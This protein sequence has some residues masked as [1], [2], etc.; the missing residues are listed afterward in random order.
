[1]NVAIERCIRIVEP[2]SSHMYF[3]IEVL[4]AALYE[5]QSNMQNCNGMID[6]PQSVPP[7][8]WSRQGG[9][10]Y[11][12]SYG[13]SVGALVPREGKVMA[14][15]S[16][17]KQKRVLS[18][19]QL[20]GP[21]FD[22][23]KKHTVQPPS[24][25][26]LSAVVGQERQRSKPQGS[27]PPS[28]Q[29]AHSSS[30]RDT[31]EGHPKHSSACGKENRR[32]A[33]QNVTTRGSEGQPMAQCEVKLKERPTLKGEERQHDSVSLRRRGSKLERCGHKRQLSP[34]PVRHNSRTESTRAKRRKVDTVGDSTRA[35][36]MKVPKEVHKKSLPRPVGHRKN[37]GEGPVGLSNKE[38]AKEDAKS[39]VL[40]MDG[41]V[42]KIGND[43]DSTC[44]RRIETKPDEQHGMEFSQSQRKSNC[45]LP[46]PTTSP[47]PTLESCAVDFEAIS[48]SAANSPGGSTIIP[49][50]TV[51]TR[52]SL[53]P[54]PTPEESPQLEDGEILSDS[55]SDV[56]S[57]PIPGPETTTSTTMLSKLTV[58]CQ[59]SQLTSR[60]KLDKHLDQ[61]VLQ[62][63]SQPP[64]HTAVVKSKTLYRQDPRPDCHR[65]RAVIE[66]HE[67]DHLPSRSHHKSRE[68]S[69]PKPWVY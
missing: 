25:E 22:E 51:G 5:V 44:R 65:K 31:H 56:R 52:S 9:V 7:N 67:R 21:N 10:L 27:P 26:L 1:M 41:I 2:C 34:S 35:Q 43:V 39:H 54:T 47:D 36:Q 37:G 30:R 6:V 64:D 12:G 18:P 16:E 20:D 53:T 57:Q 8:P 19:P 3:R 40:S 42:N 32:G 61:S 23:E 49:A 62:V 28:K 59:K 13:P 66:R 17:L 14:D 60:K 38:S 69:R 29:R 15:T 68:S 46:A 24:T 50:A 45:V 48:D 11:S 4:E 33:V 58:S 63:S 55:D